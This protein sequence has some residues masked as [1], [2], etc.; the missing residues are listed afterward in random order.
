MLAPGF[1]PDIHRDNQPTSTHNNQPQYPD[2][3]TTDVNSSKTEDIQIQNQQPKSNWPD[4]PT[5]QIPRV[6]STVQDQP[7]EVKYIQKAS[8]KLT[9]KTD[10]PDIEEDEQDNNNTEYRHL[11]PQESKRIRQEYTDKLQD[12]DDNQYFQQIDQSPELTYYLPRAPYKEPQVGA[13]QT[14]K[15]TSPQRTTEELCQLFGRGW[16]KAKQDEL[17]SHHPYGT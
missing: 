11:T 17:H 15:T 2:I 7:P 9:Q 10:I 6:S 8:T 5:V 4:A 3:D 14:A 16:G 13:T 1:D 12:L